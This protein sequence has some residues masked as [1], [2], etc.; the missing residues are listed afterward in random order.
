MALSPSRLCHHVCVVRHPLEPAALAVPAAPGWALPGFAMAPI[1][2]GDAGAVNRRL[3]ET[4][5][6]EATVLRT[7]GHT[8]DPGRRESEWIHEMELAAPPRPE[9]RW[10]GAG[11]VARLPMAERHR[12][13]LTDWLGRS[14]DDD[15]DGGRPW[16]RSGWRRRAVAWVEATLAGHGLGPVGTVEQV[17]AWETS[18][19]LRLQA[20]PVAYYLKAVP[21]RL[22][23]ELRLTA[24][25]AHEH[26]RSIPRVVAVDLTEP[27]MLSQASAHPS[28][29]EVTDV[30]AWERAAARY[31]T[32]QAAWAGRGDDVLALGCEDR[33]LG[34]LGEQIAACLADEAAMLVGEPDGL[35]A[36]EATA[37][38]AL[39]DES[40]ALCDRLASFG[41]PDALDH[42]D[43]WGANVLAAPEPLFID[44]EDAA[45]SHPFFSLFLLVLGAEESL[46]GFPD[47]PATLREAYLA[48]W[49]GRAP[50]YRLREAFAVAQ[51][52]APLRYAVSFR[53]FLA[54][55]DRVSW[56]LRGFLPYYARL[57]LASRE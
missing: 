38:P 17:R 48:S 53:D 13:I 52:L 47:V 23:R 34:R 32:L 28:L 40:A 33:R 35:T 6:V 56:E 15:V 9:A 8:F 31:G 2:P 42:G 37:L 50:D 10:L 5:S 4:A 1:H 36:G 12:E 16:Q 19:V 44:W 43:L 26:P 18:C 30:A 21:P 3:R 46:A 29:E 49:A 41:I 14:C 11:E 54:S 22:E 39:A 51:R 20:G 7:L 45:L 24:T 25:L 57:A 27:W 55:T